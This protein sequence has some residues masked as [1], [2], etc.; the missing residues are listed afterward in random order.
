VPGNVLGVQKV[1]QVIRLLN[2]EPVL[3][4]PVQLGRQP[5][6]MSKIAHMP[7]P[8]PAQR[9]LIMAARLIARG[10]GPSCLLI[11]FVL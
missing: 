10:T 11:L 5:R 2:I 3:G 9:D 8:P 1:D 4:H 6:K 7:V